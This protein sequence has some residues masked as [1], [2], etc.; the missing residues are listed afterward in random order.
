MWAVCVCVCAVVK[1]AGSEMYETKTLDRVKRKL[2]QQ[3]REQEVR[4]EARSRAGSID[5]L[6]TGTKVRNIPE[7]SLR[8]VTRPMGPG[9]WREGC[10]SRQRQ[11]ACNTKGQSLIKCPTS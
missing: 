5:T 4:E 11:C 3:A 10:K 8:V 1:M 7:F 2:R 9:E 6:Y